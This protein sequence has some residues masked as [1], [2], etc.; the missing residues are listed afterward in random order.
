MTSRVV[1]IFASMHPV[2][3]YKQYIVGP[4]IEPQAKLRSRNHLPKYPDHDHARI[5]LWQSE[6]GYA[7]L[8]DVFS[9]PDHG[10]G[11]FTEHP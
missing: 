7:L 6:P 10:R 2:I 9:A 4:D 5:I 3:I 8:D 11:P 1:E